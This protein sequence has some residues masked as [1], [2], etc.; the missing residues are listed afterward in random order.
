MGLTWPVVA[1]GG[2]VAGVGFTVSLLIASIAFEGR[3]LEEA[4]VGV[5]AAAVAA[6]ALSWVVFRIIRRLPEPVRAR[7][8]RGTEE[9]L[10]DL[11]DDVDPTRDHIRGP[12]DAPVTLLEYGDYQC[13]YCG[14]AEVAIR[15]L[16][17]SFGDDLRYVWRHLP[18]NDVHPDAQL[19][20]EAAEAAAA[21]GAF[22]EYH[23]LLLAHQDELAPTQLAAFAEELGLDVDRFWEA[24]QGRDRAARVAEDVA[25]A[26]ASEV[27][28]TPSFFINGRRYQGA[29]D[30]ET[31]TSVVA[32]AERR[33]RL[34]A[35]VAAPD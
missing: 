11:S 1:G 7:Q 27:A 35:A 18:L 8:L 9:E 31:L 12:Q 26:D 34:T 5:L 29:Y 21:Q 32:A 22:W 14:Q 6:S 10:V 3:R 4:K 16:I 28:G 33:R 19:A 25:T 30:L 20:A 17:E 13:P 2:V 23:D 15:E 24:L